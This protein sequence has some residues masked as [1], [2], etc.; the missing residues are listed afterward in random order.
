V[1]WALQG[2]RGRT[3]LPNPEENSFF[4]YLQVPGSLC[5]ARMTRQHRKESSSLSCSRVWVWSSYPIKSEQ[6]VPPSQIQL[7]T[8]ILETTAMSPRSPVPSDPCPFCPYESCEPYE[9]CVLWD[10]SPVFLVPCLLWFLWPV[11]PVPCEL[12]APW[13]LCPVLCKPCAL[14][15][16]SLSPVCYTY[17]SLSCLVR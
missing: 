12:Y 7:L 13:D 4:W 16:V 9:P 2:R 8:K 5:S 6:R 1:Q 17:C 15:H 10:L 14:S 3:W 11:S